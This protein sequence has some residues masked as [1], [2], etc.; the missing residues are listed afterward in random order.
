M[1][2]LLF[3][4][5]LCTNL[6][7]GASSIKIDSC[8]NITNITAD[9]AYFI[10]KENNHSIENISTASFKPI[11]FNFFSSDA[12][13]HPIWFQFDIENKSK[14]TIWL[15]IKNSGIL[16]ANLYMLNGMDS[17]SHQ[18]YTCLDRKGTD[19]WPSFT[20]NQSGTH[21][22]FYL[23]IEMA[24]PH[25]YG[26]YVGSK[27]AMMIKKADFERTAYLFL[28]GMILIFL[29]NLGLL[30]FLRTRIYLIYCIYIIFISATALFIIDFPV[31]KFII[32]ANITF[33][34]SYLWIS[35]FVFSTLF[36]AYTYLKISRYS[37]LKQIYRIEFG[38]MVVAFILAF[39]FPLPAIINFVRIPP[40]LIFTTC[41][42]SG[43]YLA[44]KGENTARIY[45]LGW[46]FLII[47]VFL[48]IATMNGLINYSPQLQNMVIYGTS[49]EVL[50]FSL[51]LTHIIQVLK[52]E[53]ATLN[54][55]LVLSNEKY[56]SLN[57]SLD[58]FNYHV[59]HELKTVINNMLSLSKM[60]QKYHTKQDQAK[61]DSILARLENVGKNGSDTIT[62]F[63]NLSF[64]EGQ[65]NAH[66]DIII[67][68]KTRL[69][70]IVSDNG[71]ELDL[72]LR[73]EHFAFDLL[74]IHPTV[75]DTIFLN[76]MTNAV[77]YHHPI[78]PPKIVIKT[79]V[80]K[81]AGIIHFSD[82]GIGID[83][84]KYKTDLFAP[85]KRIPNDL[86]QIGNGV[87][88]FTVKKLM[89]GYDGK[90]EVN[91]I[92]GTGTTFELHFPIERC[93]QQLKH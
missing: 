88:L 41:L 16:N 68:L 93:K 8:T 11:S 12:T 1:K 65:F 55:E 90:I 52:S 82:N 75:F 53:Q 40:I 23:R 14:Q 44:I 21:A 4:L 78:R 54:H 48:S 79:T 57:A 32:G 92:V 34:Y 73:F 59:S 87:G 62:A 89:N 37:I 58:S 27:E 42:I 77:K 74:K 24:F 47:G 45:T 76:L 3:F 69:S 86:N 17:I 60:A 29:Y 85:F 81:D 46:V 20:L 91:S 39:F 50:I 67:N 51:G 72:E 7:A 80:T 5:F 61:M 70:Q 2:S 25:L 13:L 31:V 30:I 28:G 6:A 64:S 36:F 84:D 33:N 10:D 38:L 35:G 22:Q 26:F 15:F 19:F 49:L 43:I 18:T 9:V 66:E 56:R 63:L 71:L 83:L